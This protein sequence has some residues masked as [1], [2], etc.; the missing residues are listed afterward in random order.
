[1]K[2]LE[3]KSEDDLGSTNVIT[4]SEHRCP[5]F[6]SHQTLQQTQVIIKQTHKGKNDS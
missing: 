2:E 4:K 3:E 6:H 5:A 1:M